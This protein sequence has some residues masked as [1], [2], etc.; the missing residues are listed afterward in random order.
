MWGMAGVLFTSIGAYDL[1]ASMFYIL[2][3]LNVA[4]ADADTTL[5]DS[6]INTPESYSSAGRQELKKK[7]KQAIRGF[8]V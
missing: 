1:T 4:S 8:A 3:D 5:L 7:Q 2:C 6:T